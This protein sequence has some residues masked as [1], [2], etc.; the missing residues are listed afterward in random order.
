MRQNSRKVGPSTVSA[1]DTA[2][3]VRSAARAHIQRVKRKWLLVSFVVLA[4]Y[5]ILKAIADAY[6]EHLRSGL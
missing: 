3:V 4:L 5:L 6:A 2:L 1:S